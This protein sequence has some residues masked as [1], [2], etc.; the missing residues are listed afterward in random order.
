MSNNVDSMFYWLILGITATIGKISGI[1]A[2]VTKA[3][4][5]V[6]L[7]VHEVRYLPQLEDALPAFIIAGGCALISALINKLFGLLWQKVLILTKRK[8]NGSSK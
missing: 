6:T 2:I 1:F 4:P 5:T 3:I 8:T 7:P